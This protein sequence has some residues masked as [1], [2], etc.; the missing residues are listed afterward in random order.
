MHGQP[1]IKSIVTLR[2]SILK[3]FKRF[4]EIRHRRKS[5]IKCKNPINW[6]KKGHGTMFIMNTEHR[7]AISNGASK[8]SSLFNISMELNYSNYVMKNNWTTMKCVVN[9][10]W[11]MMRRRWVIFSKT[12]NFYFVIN[13]IYIYIYIYIYIL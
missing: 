7:L 10:R 12:L 2:L 13:N 5:G 1:H 6:G 8:L 9:Y 4:V 11:A 3:Y